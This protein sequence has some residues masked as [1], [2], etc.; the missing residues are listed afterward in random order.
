MDIG[1]EVWF[2][3]VVDEVGVVLGLYG[4]VGVEVGV[5]V[6]G[7]GVFYVVVGVPLGLGGVGVEE[8]AGIVFVSTG[9][10]SLGDGTEGNG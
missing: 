3:F 9:G 10:I 8:V 1:S 5:D 6:D 2:K 4:G 7:F